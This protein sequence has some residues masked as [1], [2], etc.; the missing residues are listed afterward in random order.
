ML[1]K[2]FFEAI[3]EVILHL[4]EVD[5]EY[6]SEKYKV[7]AAKELTEGSDEEAAIEEI[8]E[9]LNEWSEDCLTELYADLFNKKIEVSQS[10]TIMTPLLSN[11][12][13]QI[14]VS[15]EYQF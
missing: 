1:T 13:P 7:V 4:C 8:R 5:F 11:C 9:I 3:D 12:N 10:K 6:L 15:K 14:F 2:S